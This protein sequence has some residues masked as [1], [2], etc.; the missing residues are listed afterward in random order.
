MIKKHTKQQKSGTKF[1]CWTPDSLNC[2]SLSVFLNSSFVKER[3]IR[4]IQAKLARRSL[5]ILSQ[6]TKAP[7]KQLL[8]LPVISPSP[9]FSS[10]SSKNPAK[11]PSFNFPSIS[12]LREY[13][14]VTPTIAILK[15]RITFK[16]LKNCEKTIFKQ[17]K[18]R[19]PKIN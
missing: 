15:S 7:R 14:S 8:P 17:V 2:S 19:E 12:K 3:K 4:E 16:C 6:S 10:L 5:N 18:H 11:H 1:G 13:E 9:S